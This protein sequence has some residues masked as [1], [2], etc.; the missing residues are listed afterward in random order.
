MAEKQNDRPQLTDHL[1]LGPGLVVT[2]GYEVP[3]VRDPQSAASDRVLTV[4]TD[5]VA[6]AREAARHTEQVFY[7]V[8]VLSTFAGPM[9][10]LDL[11]ASAEPDVQPAPK[12]APAR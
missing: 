2:P 12:P 4:R 7:D 3:P 1:D 11:K 5:S 9:S 6:L 8:P 10:G